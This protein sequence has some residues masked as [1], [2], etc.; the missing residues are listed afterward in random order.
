MGAFVLT[1]VPSAVWAQASIAGVAK[2]ASGGVL[3]G[4]TV[5]A[6]SPALI[7]KARVVVTDGS[8]EYQIVGIRPGTYAVS[9]SLTGF[10]AVKREGIE[11]TGTSTA[12]VNAVLQTGQVNETITVTGENPVV[13]T[14]N[15]AQQQVLNKGIL[16]SIPLGRSYNDVAIVVPGLTTANMDVGGTNNLTNSQGFAIHG[17]R[18]GDMRLTV[19]GRQMRNLASNGQNTNYVP[20]FGNTQEITID[21]AA[22]SAEMATGG[23]RMNLIPREGGNMFSGSFFA[24]GVGPAFQASNLTPA[25]QA[26]GL[27]SVNGLKRQYDINPTGGG[28][29]LP[30][31]LWFFSS[32][33]WQDNQNYIAGLY[34]NLNAGNPASYIYAP[35]LSS[36][37]VTSIQNDNANARV[38]WQG[39]PRNKFSFYFDKQWRNW[40]FLSPGVSP[41]SGDFYTFP[42][43]WVANAKWTAPLTSKLLLEVSYSD[44]AEVFINTPP[45]GTAALTPIIDQSAHLLYRG[46][47]LQGPFFNPSNIPCG[48]LN[49]PNIQNIDASVSYVTGAHALKVGVSELFGRLDFSSQSVGASNFS[50]TFNKGVPTAITEYA[51]PFDEI[52]DLNDLGVYAQDSWTVKRLTLNAGLRFEY[53]TTSF[54]EYHLGPSSLLPNRN[55][56]FPATQ[57]YNYKDIDPRLGVTYDLFGD[58]KTAVKVSVGRYTLGLNGAVGN[59]VVNQANQVT[60]SWTPSLPPGS[61]NY[62]VPQCVLSN[63]LLNG[64]C[65]TISDLTFGSTKPS[66]VIDPATLGGWGARPY[67]WEFST[68]VQRELTA[69]VSATVGYFRRWYGNFT[70][71]D[72]TAVAPTDF[73]PFSLTAPVD[74]RLPGGGGYV[75]NGFYNLNPNKVGQVANYQTFASNYGSQIEHWNGFDFTIN[76]RPRGGIL[77]QGG[78]STGRTTTDDCSIVDKYLGEVSVTTSVGTAQST[79]MCH[80]QTPFLTQVKLIGTYPVPRIDVNISA[81]LQSLAGPLI[82]A[83]YVA[84]NAQV[85]PSLGR[86]LSGNA[87]NVTVNIVQPGTMYGQQ[88][89]ELDLRFEKILKFGRTKT[90][91]DLDL[92]NIANASPVLTLNNAY[93]SWLTP[94]SVL[95]ARLFRIGGRVEF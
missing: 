33:R 66:T 48:A 90:A 38:T 28:P 46:G 6:S 30:D 35:D 61:P 21:Y 77:L 16:D 76:A 68:S 25:L 34:A 15:V 87:S 44:H 57:G 89:N 22:G 58:S 13:D 88:A 39:T 72:N 59:P 71:V 62:F 14:H 36:Q 56:T 80:L 83:N 50:Y 81:T 2:D 75:I 64:D 42:R 53:F 9:F 19:D 65:G 40:N 4:V 91:V 47:C 60:R 70:V 94:L 8:G 95:G 45:S 7:E 32:V 54:P 79:Q 84:T 27:T 69:R 78:V 82:A 20:D 10:T 37:A 18:M 55:V 63:P 67:N 23:V 3:P 31:K 5:E 74:P 1:L 41:E 12:T 92:Y 51:T 52:D 49:S 86:A 43:D 29:I 17:S 73:S 26:Q 85:Q 93:G 11:V 24:T